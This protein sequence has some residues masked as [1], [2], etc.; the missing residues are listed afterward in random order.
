M[1]SAHTET[2][3]ARG[4]ALIEVLLAL[5][6]L[7]IS[8]LSLLPLTVNSLQASEQSLQQLL[9]SQQQRNRRAYQRLGLAPP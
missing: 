2:E 7:A 3:T 9:D 1:P 5:A 6:L 8:L 4:I